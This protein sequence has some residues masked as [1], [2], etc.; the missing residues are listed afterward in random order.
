MCTVTFIPQGSNDFVLTSNRDEAPN[1]ISLPPELYTFDKTKMLFPKDE[2]A[3]GTWIGV[4]DKN[5]MI[6]LLN[7]GFTYHE[8]KQNYR[9]SRG[10]VVKYLLASSHVANAVKDYDLHDVEP[11]TL[12]IADWNDSLQLME[13]V[14][15]GHRKHFTTLPLEPKLWSSSSLYS[16]TMKTERFKW[17]KE[18]KKKND[19]SSESLYRF[20]KTA[21]FGNAN[22]G[23][24]MDRGFVKTT[25]ITQVEKTNDVIQMRYDNLKDKDQV[26]K[27]F[28]IHQVINE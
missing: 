5:R 24:I 6:C 20:H 3:G 18:F 19:L 7:G 17:F 14:W 11:F 21:G 8:R 25:S 28:K 22:Y 4:S 27:K 23:V 12:I 26:S 13:L 1:R 9:L 15:D 16:E 2:V 10:T